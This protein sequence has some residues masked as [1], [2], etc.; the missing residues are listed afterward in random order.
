[1]AP[2]GC[3]RCKGNDRWITI[4]CANQKEWESFCKATDNSQWTKDERFIDDYDRI[5]NSQD[6]DKIIE[7]W[8][9]NHTDYEI[10]EKLQNNGVAAAP[11]F[12]QLDFFTDSHAQ[13]EEFMVPL[14]HPAEPAGYVYN[15][16][17]KMSMTPG[18]M[19]RHAPILGENN[20]YVLCNICGLTENE[21]L[22]LIE[23]KV[24]W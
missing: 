10:M 11:V 14:P 18:K 1:M 6:L 20:K 24:V 21:Y 15:T 16:P 7:E 12:N 17:W 8:T 2:H 4:A 9:R 5:K 22:E 13:E 23:T 19:R 3:Y